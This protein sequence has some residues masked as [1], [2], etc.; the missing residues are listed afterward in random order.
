MTDPWLGVEDTSLDSV[1][2]E[3]IA[4]TDPLGDHS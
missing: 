4:K 3:M 2:D 1:D